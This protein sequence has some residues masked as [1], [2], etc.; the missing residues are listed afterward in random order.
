MKLEKQTAANHVLGCAIGLPP[1]PEA[2]KLLRQEI[3]ALVRV[4]ANEIPYLL[5]LPLRENP[6]PVSNPVIHYNCYYHEGNYERKG[7]F[8]D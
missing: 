2:A 3:P 6:A 4:T 1:I 8:I 7:Y 5:Y